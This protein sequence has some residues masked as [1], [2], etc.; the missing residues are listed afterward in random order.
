MGTLTGSYTDPKHLLQAPFGVRSHWHQP[1]RASMET[2]PIST[3]LGVAGVNWN[4]DAS[5]N[6]ALLARMLSSHGIARMRMEVSWPSLDDATEN[7]PASGWYPTSV[8]A[9]CA[10]YG[11]RPTICLNSNHG[12]PCPNTALTKTLAAP[13]AVGAT[14]VTLTDVT[15]IIVGYTGLSNLSDYIMAQCLITSIAG[16][17]CTLSRPVPSAATGSGWVMQ[18]GTLANGTA[19]RLDTL[20]YKPF[21]QPGSADYLASIAGWTKYVGVIGAWLKAQMGLGN[22]DIEVWNELTFGSNFLDA[23]YYTGNSNPAATVEGQYEQVMQDTAIYVAAHPELFAGSQLI[24]GF[25]SQVPAPSSSNQHPRVTA[26]NRHPYFSR[27]AISPGVVPEAGTKVNATGTVDASGYEPT[28]TLGCPEIDSLLVT[29]EAS[30][31]D[32]GPLT[33]TSVGKGRYAR[34][35]VDGSRTPCVGYVTEGGMNPNGFGVTDAPTALRQKAKINL[36]Y[37]VG[38]A[39]KGR[40]AVCLWAMD[41]SGDLGGTF[42]LQSFLAL[43]AQAGATY[44]VDD[45]SSTSPLL[46]TL[47]RVMAVAAVGAGPAPSVPYGGQRRIEVASVSDTHDDVQFVGDGTAAHPTLYDRDCL[48]ILPFQVNACRFVIPYYVVTRDVYHVYNGALTGGQQY[49]LPPEHFTVALTGLVGRGARITAYDP[50]NNVF[51][52]VGVL[53]ADDTGATLDLIA[54]DYPYL[55]VWQEPP[56]DRAAGTRAFPERN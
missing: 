47:A 53:A 18:N 33:D 8:L 22:Y 35:N 24:N 54:A 30:S 29:T 31:R 28:Y 55:L 41:D 49:D 50:L 9:A 25:A 14:T 10:A 20:K 2:V 42:T 16:N 45:T 40:I 15:G 23:R 5:H 3:L 4:C 39:A 37:W 27:F 17:V 21:G 26:I 6:P 32:Y 12:G 11:I 1:W 34:L 44:P 46:A 7:V 19:V 38:G 43:T 56:P 48:A 52:P 51:V 36:R 13:L